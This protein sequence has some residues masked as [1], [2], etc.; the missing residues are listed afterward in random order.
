MAARRQDRPLHGIAAITCL[1]DAA[2]LEHI[3]ANPMAA[4]RVKLP[5]RPKPSPAVMGA[6][7]GTIFQA[8]E[9]TRLY[10]F[11]VTAACSGCL[12]SNLPPIAPSAI[13]S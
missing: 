13:R 10:P 2:R 5:K 9:G 7:P 6:A 3:P 1:G 4:R 8:A 11:I 12:R